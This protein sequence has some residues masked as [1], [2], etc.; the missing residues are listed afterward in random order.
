LPLALTILSSND[1]PRAVST[2]LPLVRIVGG[3]QLSLTLS[4][5]PSA[6]ALRGKSIFRATIFAKEFSEL[7][8]SEWLRKTFIIIQF[9]F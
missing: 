3:C 8:F 1:D 9:G 2:R 4:Y 7:N 6:T 5:D